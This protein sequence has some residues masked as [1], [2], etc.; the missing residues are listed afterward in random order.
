MTGSCD[1]KRRNTRCHFSEACG[2]IFFNILLVSSCSTKKKKAHGLRSTPVRVLHGAWGGYALGTWSDTWKEL[3]VPF[4][5][6]CGFK[7]RDIH[8]LLY[9]PLR[10]TVFKSNRCSSYRLSYRLSR[11]Y[12]AIPSQ[13]KLDIPVVYPEV[14]SCWAAEQR[15]QNFKPGRH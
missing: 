13:F 8:A 12:C 10:V 2:N 15:S 3:R 6:P 11:K 5:S 4:S 14:C 9:H 7:V 1:A